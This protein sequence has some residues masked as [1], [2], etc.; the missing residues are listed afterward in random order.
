MSQTIRL[1]CII[2]I[3]LIAAGGMKPAAADVT[4]TY[5]GL[6][7]NSLNNDNPAAFMFTT[8]EYVTA[9]FELADYLPANKT[10]GNYGQTNTYPIS[11]SMSA[12]PVTNSSANADDLYTFAIAT[13]AGGNIIDWD[14][15]SISQPYGSDTQYTN[16]MRTFQYSDAFLGY[17]YSGN[18][19]VTDD[20]ISVFPVN[21]DYSAYPINGGYAT[22]PGTWVVAQTDVPEP[23]SLLLLGS[24][25]ALLAGRRTAKAANRHRSV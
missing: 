8:S 3:T 1:L 16:N 14:M 22:N 21:G 9:S 6:A 5:T 15:F 13:D 12:G 11:W 10:M 17:P 25:V 20:G 18:G 4:Y 19:N 2:T 7:F 23:G 24:G